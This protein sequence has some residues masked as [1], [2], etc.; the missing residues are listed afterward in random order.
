ME[1]ATKLLLVGLVLSHLDYANTI[2][3][4]SSKQWSNRTSFHF[5]IDKK[6]YISMAFATPSYVLY[7][8]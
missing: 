8:L 6:L 1:E 2:L 4:G 3:A 5:Y 7:F